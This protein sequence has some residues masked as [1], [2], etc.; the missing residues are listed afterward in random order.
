MSRYHRRDFLR[1]G[2]ALAAG[3]RTAI[4][5]GSVLA[6]GLEKI[7]TKR[8][9]VLWMQGLSCTGCSVSLLNAESPS[10][11]QVLTELISLTYHST[12]FRR[13]RRRRR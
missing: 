1:M 12:R 2:A 9:P 11:L 6:D 5:P 3:A 8:V 13:P 4:R 10:I 7:F